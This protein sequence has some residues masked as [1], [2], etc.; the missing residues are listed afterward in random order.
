[1]KN[2]ANIVFILAAF[3]LILAPFLF[4]PF[5]QNQAHNEKEGPS[6]LPSLVESDGTF[7]VDFLSD[8]GTFF[9]ENFAF[10][11]EL[12]AM[13][14]AIYRSV[15]TSASDS[16]IVGNDGWLFYS[17]S[18]NDFKRKNQLSER[19]LQNI[20]HNLSFVQKYCEE[21]GSKFVFVCPPNK[22]E[23][24]TDKMPYYIVKG[25]GENNWERLKPYLDEFGVNYVDTYDILS[26]SDEALYLKT[27][28]HW[29]TKGAFACAEAILGVSQGPSP[30]VEGSS[31]AV[32]GS[33]PAVEG[34]SPASEGSSP[35]SEGP[36]PLMERTVPSSQLTGDLEKL[37]NP[38]SPS[39]EV[40]EYVEGV[41]DGEG[42][43]GSSWS[44]TTGNS[45]ED[46]TI[47]TKSSSNSAAGSL[48]MYRDSFGNAL[49]PFMATTFE[50]A[51]FSKLVPYNLLLVD[52]NIPNVVVIERA[53]RH[54]S[55]LAEVAPIMQSPKAELTNTSSETKNMDVQLKCSKNGPYTILE[56]TIPRA[57]QAQD[58]K[59]Y[60][61]LKNE[62]GTA[63]T[64]ESYNTS[65]NLPDTFADME[66]S[67]PTVLD[68]GEQTDFGFSFYLDLEA[69]D[70]EGC[71]F[72]LSVDVDG[73]ATNIKTFEY[74]SLNFDNDK[75]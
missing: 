42:F 14:N 66:G 1:M 23:L 73:V 21:R 64:F 40:D 75:E 38:L 12:I 58:A 52:D 46:S 24:Y 4:M 55:Y 20:A 50:N 29:N 37:I 53:Q 11:N 57:F 49:L 56:G 2:R 13:N 7:N 17:G 74:E 47:T 44:F 63:T 31:P 30:A 32:E 34:S 18:L 60:L 19:A 35:A 26:D 5:F 28:S 70:A 33:S 51:T 71:E 69:Y 22:N 39:S 67:S 54:L 27:D 3:A 72:T 8:F 48:L 65:H 43:T 16:V 45:V 62:A 15:L 25:E 10:R 41:N 9:E 68:N 36:S 61:T 6:P 59:C